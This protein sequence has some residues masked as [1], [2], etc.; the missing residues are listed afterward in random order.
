MARNVYKTVTSCHSCAQTG[1]TLENKGQL[2]RVL[3]KTLLKFVTINIF[4]RLA[5]KMA[6][7]H[8][9]VIIADRQSKLTRAVSSARITNTA[10]RCNIL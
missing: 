10:V 2:K 5:N 1:I 7:N 9:V 8:H 4:G 6:G 3:A